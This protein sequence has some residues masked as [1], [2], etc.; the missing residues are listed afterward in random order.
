MDMTLEMTFL[1]KLVITVKKPT[2]KTKLLCHHIRRMLEPNVTAKLKDKNTTIQSY[3]DV[4]D[5]F[6]LSHFILVDARDIK[7]G[8]RP[9]G[10]TYVFNVVDYNPKYININDEYYRSD[11]CITFTGDSQFK[12]LFSSL[13]SQPETFKRNIHFYFEDDLIHVRHYA[14]LTKDE[15]DIKVGFNEIG[16]R[17]TMRFVKMMKGFFK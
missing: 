16:P 17:I 2:K 12:D 11:P 14:I 8:V 6:E 9:A 10:P 7:I 13:S 1:N 3:L 4:A 15:D 5:A